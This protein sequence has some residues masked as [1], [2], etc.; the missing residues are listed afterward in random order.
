MTRRA[1]LLTLLGAVLAG[2]AGT[3]TLLPPAPPPGA[4]LSPAEAHR[5]ASAGELALVDIRTPAEWAETGIPRGAATANYNALP[6]DAFI[7]RIERLLDGERSRPVA[8]ICARGG[9]SSRARALLSE[10]GF[11]E[12]YDVQEGMLGNAGGPGWLDRGLPLESRQFR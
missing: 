1:L 10:A 2:A 3:A 8:L 7:A 6:E 12:V 9:R 4:V 5:A 11:A